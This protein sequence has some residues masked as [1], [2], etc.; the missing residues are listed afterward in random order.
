MGWN[1]GILSFLTQIFNFF[2]F[3]SFFQKNLHIYRVFCYQKNTL[4]VKLNPKRHGFWFSVTGR[5]RILGFSLK[6]NHRIRNYFFGITE[7]VNRHWD[8]SLS[9]IYQ[10]LSRIP[11]KMIPLTRVNVIFLYKKRTFRESQP[12]T[13][14]I[15]CIW[16]SQNHVKWVQT[17]HI[18][19]LR[20]ILG[21]KITDSLKLN[22]KSH[23]RDWEKIL[24]SHIPWFLH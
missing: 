7:S 8:F 5:S 6:K 14:R 15:V 1:T 23:D 11:W 16:H 20:V 24:T 12:K 4:S 22:P 3:F 17:Y 10:K 13:P 21:Q 18:S 2:F 19:H 9:S